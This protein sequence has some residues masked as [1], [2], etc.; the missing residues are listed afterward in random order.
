[1]LL[2]RRGREF[3]GHFPGQRLAQLVFVGLAENHRITGDLQNVP[4]KYG[5]VFP[6][7]ICLVESVGDDCDHAAI[8]F[9]DALEIDLIDG[10]AALARAASRT[11]RASSYG[12]DEWIAL[13][14][15][16]E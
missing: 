11:G 5:I 10:Q 14:G 3:F 6:Q 15:V 1:M 16:T 12:A 2:H 7:E 4:V 9:N 13:S 8:G